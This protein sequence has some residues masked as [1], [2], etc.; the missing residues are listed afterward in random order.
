VVELLA[1]KKRKKKNKINRQIGNGEKIIGP[2]NKGALRK[3]IE[4]RIKRTEAIFLREVVETTIQ[5]TAEHL[6]LTNNNTTTTSNK[7]NATICN[8]K[9]T[10]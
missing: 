1:N 2:K 10:L 7:E 3:V 8:L 5:Q 4:L 9:H 6:T